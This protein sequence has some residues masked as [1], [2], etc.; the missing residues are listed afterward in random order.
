M[1]LGD[2]NYFV[3]DI[4]CNFSLH[5][6]ID[7]K[8]SKP[9]VSQETI[10]DAFQTNPYRA[11]REY[12]NRFDNDGG[13]DCFVKRSTILKYSKT[14]TPIFENDGTKTYI[15]AY[16]PSTKLDNSVIMIAELFREEERGYMVKFVNCVNL[17]EVLKTGEK[18]V[19]QK[20]EQIKRLK[21]IIVDYNKGALD[22]DNLDLIVIDA[23][24]GGLPISYRME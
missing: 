2:P 13:E 11:T 9:L 12:W 16:D 21:D 4:D 14:F 19:I 8:P 20:P 10:D 3:C 15:I 24:A 6:F 22:Y 18:A 17:I 7:G 23:G 5:P 1:M